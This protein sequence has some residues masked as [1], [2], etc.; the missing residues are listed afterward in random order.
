MATSFL[1]EHSVEYCLVYRLNQLMSPRWNVIPLFFWRSREG[2][3]I[4][5]M[6]DRGE[7]IRVMAVYARRPKLSSPGDDAIIM[8]VND[9]VFSRANY[10][11]MQGIPVFCGVPL[12][13]RVLDFRMDS[14]CAWFYLAS[15]NTYIDEE[16]L[17]DVKT[18]AVRSRTDGSSIEPVDEHR[19]ASIIEKSIS[20]MKLSDA[21][22]KLN[23]KE[24]EGLRVR[25]PPFGGIYKPAYLFMA[26]RETR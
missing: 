22:Q 26:E 18:G 7:Q 14:P 20:P 11:T 16:L 15:K 25:F 21:I 12:V 6:C 17:L 13:S 5:K 2:S 24:G 8:K 3:T 4:S 1:S 23:F 9:H 19:I 10:L